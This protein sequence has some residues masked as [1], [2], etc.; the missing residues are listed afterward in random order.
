MLQ[1][2][3]LCLSLLSAEE[4]FGIYL[5]VDVSFIIIFFNGKFNLFCLFIRT[6]HPSRDKPFLLAYRTV[7][8]LVWPKPVVVKLQPSLFPYWSGSPHSPRLTGE[9]RLEK[10]ARVKYLHT[11]P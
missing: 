9:F 11:P 8:S 4:M 2:C 3:Q 1:L 6:Q 5:A 10:S 7:T